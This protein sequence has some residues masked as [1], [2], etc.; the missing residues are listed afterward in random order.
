MIINYNVEKINR[1]LEDFYKSTGIYMVLFKDDFSCVGNRDYWENNHYCRA[2]QNTDCGENAC[3]I[4]DLSLLDRCRKSRKAEMHICHAGLVDVALPVLYDDVII[5]YVMFG[6]MKTHTDFASVKKYISGIGLDTAKMQKLY[7]AI[8]VYDS[9]KLSSVSN[10]AQMLV[11]YIL[12]ENLMKPDFDEKMQNAVS[13]IDA[14]LDKELSFRTISKNINVSKSV[15]YKRFRDCFNCTVSEYINAKRVE[16]SIEYL[17]KTDLSVEEV[18]QRS[19]FS[20]AS[21]YG[22]VF[23][24]LKGCTP[25][26]YRKSRE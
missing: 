26:S 4:S 16:K 21:Y 3:L 19:G 13:F 9:D 22:K 2:V 18:A 6:Q 11:K 25:S 15:L 14:N 23:K 12:L 17:T 1:V 20:D 7:A 5:G 24:R 8:P 10:I